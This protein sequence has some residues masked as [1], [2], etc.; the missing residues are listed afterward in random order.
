MKLDLTYLAGV[1][2]L[3]AA[4]LPVRDA[5]SKG[6]ERSNETPTAATPSVALM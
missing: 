4:A 2:F 3:T 6:P 5:S 1:A